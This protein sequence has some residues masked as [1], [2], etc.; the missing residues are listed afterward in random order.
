MMP[1]VV[2]RVPDG[3]F[4]LVPI[5]D[6]TQGHRPHTLPVARSQCLQTCFTNRNPA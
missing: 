6:A 1:E 2:Q 4:L 5:S 3:K